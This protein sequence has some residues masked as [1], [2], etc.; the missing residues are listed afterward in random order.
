MI[1]QDYLVS[2]WLKTPSV[3]EVGEELKYYHLSN[4]SD[5]V[6]HEEALEYLPAR[7]I[8]VFGR[9]IMAIQ[10]VCHDLRRMGAGEGDGEK[11][12]A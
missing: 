9:V 5:L 6:S 12:Q 1:L 8:L 3:K 11:V 2:R 10:H 4:V 7:L